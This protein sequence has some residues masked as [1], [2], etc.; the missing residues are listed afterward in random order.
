MF[1]ARRRGILPGRRCDFDFDFRYVFSAHGECPA[2]FLRT[3]LCFCFGSGL[4]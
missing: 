2:R 1:W 4:S 3:S